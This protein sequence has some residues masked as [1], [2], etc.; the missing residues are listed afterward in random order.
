MVLVTGLLLR[1]SWRSD[2]DVDVANPPVSDSFYFG[3]FV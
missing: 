1:E 2:N 3:A